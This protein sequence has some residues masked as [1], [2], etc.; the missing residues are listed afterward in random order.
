MWITELLEEQYE[1]D[2]LMNDGLV[3]KTTLDMDV[4]EIAE[5]SILNNKDSLDMYGATNQSMIYL[6]TESGDILAYV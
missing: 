2:M 1:K 6:D 4:Q 3:V 5:K